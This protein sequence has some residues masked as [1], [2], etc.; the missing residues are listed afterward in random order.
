MKKIEFNP[1]QQ[2]DNP[3]GEII[4]FLDIFQP[5]GNH[6]WA[7]AVIKLSDGSYGISEYDASLRFTLFSYDYAESSSLSPTAETPGKAIANFM[8]IEQSLI[9][10]L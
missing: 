5:N 8:E 9:D 1:T 10:S 7:V 6:K 2:F 3:N 4:N